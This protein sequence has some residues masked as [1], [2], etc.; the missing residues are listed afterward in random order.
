MDH[1][2]YERRHSN[3]ALARVYRDDDGAGY[4]P[5][6]VPHHDGGRDSEAYVDTID[7]AQAQADAYAHPGCTGAGCGA[8]R[9]VSTRGAVR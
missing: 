3:G 7:G 5:A 9:P 2:C 1:L 6:A 4:R 8:W